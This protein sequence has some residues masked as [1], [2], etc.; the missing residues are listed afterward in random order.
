MIDAA[1]HLFLEKGYGATTLNDIVSRSGGS[2]S[3]LYELFENKSGL[4]RAVVEDASDDL[5]R[6]IQS[7]TIDDKR[8][9]EALSIIGEYFSQRLGDPELMSLLRVIANETMKFPELGSQFYA[10][11]PEAA[12]RLIGG[13]LAR[14]QAQGLLVVNNPEEAAIL[15]L[16]M[17]LGESHL[18][19]LCG[20]PAWCS[21]AK[22]RQHVQHIVELFLRLHEVAD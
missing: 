15:F 21:D 18:R 17:L 8:P 1:R 9:H 7:A 16:Q 3:T 4:L 22:R 11:G 19:S 6:A 14:Q 12:H 5:L 2:L 10:S 13:Y 20:L